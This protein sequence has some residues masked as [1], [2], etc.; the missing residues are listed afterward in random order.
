MKVLRIA[1][2]TNDLGLSRSSV[3]S[4]MKEGAFPKPISLGARSVG[5]LDFEIFNWLESR[6]IDRDIGGTE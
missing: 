2:V 4:L 6:R 1:Q 5:W 3:Y